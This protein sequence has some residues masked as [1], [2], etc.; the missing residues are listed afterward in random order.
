[1]G[2]NTVAVILNDQ[3]S[4]IAKDQKFGDSI[5]QAVS[6]FGLEKH[7][8]WRA[9]RASHGAQIISLGHADY[10]Q[11]CVVY[12]NTGW[13]IHDADIPTGAVQAVADA[14][15]LKGYHVTKSKPKSEA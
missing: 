1:M 14:L 2:F 5:S 6:T 3:L 7:Y 10:P 11:V 12:G 9:G 15:R 4:E 8:G 13:S